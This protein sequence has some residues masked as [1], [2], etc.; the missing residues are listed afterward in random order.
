MELESYV[1]WIFYSQI[2]LGCMNC[3]IR[4]DFNVVYSLL[5]YYIWKI[6]TGKNAR[7][8]VKILFSEFNMQNKNSC[9]G[10]ILEC[11]QWMHYGS[12]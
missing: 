10:S 3:L 9:C 8:K 4:V 5:C 6:E 1:P 12:L 2:V 7:T 11:L